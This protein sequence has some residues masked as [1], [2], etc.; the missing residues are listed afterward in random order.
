VEPPAYG[1]QKGK[2][3][4]LRQVRKKFRAGPGKKVK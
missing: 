4:G 2:L 3:G 1:H